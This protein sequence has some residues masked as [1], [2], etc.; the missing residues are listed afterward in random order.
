MKSDQ[1]EYSDQFKYKV[2]IFEIYRDRIVGEYDLISTRMS[3][4]LISLGAF[5]IVSSTIIAS[6]DDMQLALHCLCGLLLLGSLFLF[7]S[8]VS[9]KAAQSE[10]E[11][12]RGQYLETIKMEKLESV[13]PWVDK[14][15]VG[16]GGR[17]KTANTII[18]LISGG[19]P[20]VF[21]CAGT[22]MFAGAWLLGGTAS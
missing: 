1:I 8:R 4:P 11:A 17:H 13:S 6:I 14:L 2:A 12:L 20:W 7:A 10:I 16:Q 3:W 19:I 15:I 21:L 22:A 5:A 9:V 18:N